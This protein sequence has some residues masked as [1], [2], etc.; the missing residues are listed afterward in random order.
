MTH[1]VSTKVILYSKKNIYKKIFVII[2]F[3]V[4]IQL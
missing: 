2:C 3:A 1:I 4:G